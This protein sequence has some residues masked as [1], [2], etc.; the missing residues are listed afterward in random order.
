[1]DEFNYL[2][3]LD[4]KN[5]LLLAEDL[6]FGEFPTFSVYLHE[7]SSSTAAQNSSGSESSLTETNEKQTAKNPVP[8]PEVDFPGFVWFRVKQ[9][10][11][12]SKS[13]SIKIPV[14]PQNSG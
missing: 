4:D 10:K 11:S 3:F 8:T 14:A 5:E 13:L 1:M 7:Y 6:N 9:Y 12:S 2:Q